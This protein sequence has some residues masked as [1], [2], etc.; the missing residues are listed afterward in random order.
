MSRRTTIALG[1]V[2]VSLLAF[3]VFVERDSLTTGELNARKGRLLE[4]FVRDRVTRIVIEGGSEAVELE[5]VEKAPTLEKEGSEDLDQ[6]GGTHE[7][8][9]WRLN[10]PVEAEADDSVVASLL[11][12]LEW[13]DARVELRDI[14]E[15][16]RKRFGLVEPRRK[17]IID[18]AR[19]AIELR[20]GADEPTSGGV[21]AE[22]AGSTSAYVVGRDL[23]EAIDHPAGHFRA[24]VLFPDFDGEALSAIEIDRQIEPGSAAEGGSEKL[25]L[26]REKGRWWL[27]EP[28]RFWASKTAMSSIVQMLSTLKAERFI[29]S[30]PG[31][32]LGTPS[33]A[34]RISTGTT[35][36]TLYVGNEC[37]NNP[38]E[39][40]AW[41]DAGPHVCVLGSDLGP[42]RTPISELRAPELS[43]LRRGELQAVVLDLDGQR[44]EL[45]QSGGWSYDGSKGKGAVDE[46][47]LEVWLERIAR[48]RATSVEPYDPA[49]AKVL[50]LAKPRGRLVFRGQEEGLEDRIEIGLAGAEGLYV[51]RGDEP[52]ISRFAPEAAEV[53]AIGPLTFRSLALIEEPPSRLRRFTIER[54]G[55]VETLERS[56][57]FSSWGVSEP[58]QVAADLN[59]VEELVPLFARLQ[60]LRFV[61]EKK[62]PVH[63]LEKPAFVVRL[64]FEG[65]ASEQD[66]QQDHD[67]HDHGGHD[68][69]PGT[70]DDHVQAP[71]PRDHLLYIGASTEGGAF[72]RLD[73]DP[74]VFI[75]GS[76][77]VLGIED[78][79]VSRELLSID[80]ALIEHIV[81][82][83]GGSSLSLRRGTNG[84]EAEAKK[85]ERPVVDRLIA[86]LTQLRPTRVGSYGSPS[87]VEGPGKPRLTIEIELSD[88]ASAD[89]PRSLVVGLSSEGRLAIRRTDLDVGFWIDEVAVAPLFDALQ[90]PSR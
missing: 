30:A 49:R 61:A 10:E 8:H 63:G 62:E 74:A 14:S 21:Y 87:V 58:L 18:V 66:E 75:I 73:D 56:D 22:I 81:L 65:K 41:I 44:F 86:A 43:S 80:E 19:E 52:W 9:A 27:L 36:R 64:R 55:P 83:A 4:R 12:S 29:E 77:V 76:D 31:P 90:I 45:Q 46:G 50:G 6:L 70:D 40:E 53:I 16:D 26:S 48:L 28:D 3:I 17:I 51:R 37:A 89:A 84:F 7:E 72:A 47:A 32:L 11:G 24:K 42:L 33:V 82:R 67:G 1:V 54:G 25:L 69:G 60:A 71:A 5:R 59:R 88:L 2:A 39:V 34:L 13:A 23:Y 15:A 35:A 57:A 68:H 85:L 78:P 20:F 38:E 79:L